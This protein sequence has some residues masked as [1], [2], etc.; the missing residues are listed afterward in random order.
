MPS[1]SSSRPGDTTDPGCDGMKTALVLRPEPGLSATLHR[2]EG[3]E[4]WWGI[5]LP[6][7]QRDPTRGPRPSGSFD[8]IAFTSGEATRVLD[9]HAD[10][11]TLPIHAVGKETAR[12]ARER[13]ARSV[14][15][16]LGGDVPR[17]GAE[18]GRSLGA[19]YRGR[20]I[21]YPCA[22]ERR[23]GFEREAT[24]Q[25][26]FVVSWPIYRTTADP[27]AQAELRALLRDAPPE[28]IL[29]HAPSAARALAHAAPIPGG[30]ALLCLS[31]AIAAALPHGSAT[32]VLVAD[33]PDDDALLSLLWT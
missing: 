4:G 14:R 12:H 28:A 21:L 22:V 2:I 29:L 32:R 30:V 10:L 6:L 5:G 19:H 8:A 11:R 26:A 3:I 9:D 16:G 1:S 24:R 18:L 7:T 31:D 17:D 27:Q 15:V 33:R 25:G 13:G 20:I 23:P